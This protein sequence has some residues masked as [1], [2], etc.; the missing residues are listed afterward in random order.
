[1]KR[2][3]LIGL[4]LSAILLCFSACTNED[5]GETIQSEIRIDESLL[6]NGLSFTSEEGSQSISFSTNEDWSLNVATT[7]SGVVWCTASATSGQKGDAT[8]E[9]TVT[10]NNS[11]D[12]RNVAVTIQ[13]GTASKTFSIS[14]KWAD[15]LL[16]TTDK[17]EISQTGGTIEIEVNANIDYEMEIAEDSKKW[18]TESNTRALTAYKHTLDIAINEELE[19]REG[20]IYFKSGDKIETVKVYQAGGAIIMLSQNEYKISDAGE[21]ITIN[22]KSNIEY[23]VLMP[24]VDWITDEASTRGLSSHTLKYIISPND[25]YDSRSAEIIFYD[26]NSELKEAV[27][28]VQTQKNAIILS[29]KQITIDSDSHTIEV[30]VSANVDFNIEMPDVDWISHTLPT[31]GLTDHIVKF[32]VLENKEQKNREAQIVFKDKESSLS[33]TLII[34]QHSDYGDYIIYTYIESIDHLEQK[35]IQVT[36]HRSGTLEKTINLIDYSTLKGAYLLKVV[37][38]INGDDIYYIREVFSG[39]DRLK[40]YELDLSEA[41]IVEGGKEYYY[42]YR[43]SRNTIEQSMF[44]DLS[45]LRS[46][47][48]PDSAISIERYALEF[49]TELVLATIGNGVTSIGES[50]FYGCSKLRQIVIPDS[51]TTLESSV[52]SR[53]IQLETAIIG[54]EATSI[55]DY[56]FDDCENLTSVTIGNSVTSIGYQAFDGCENLTSVIIPNSVTKIGGFAFH[57]CTSLEYATLGNGIKSIAGG[58]FKNCSALETIDVPNSVE[59]IENGA[60]QNCSS[61]K[62]I[63]IGEGVATIEADVFKGC[64]A[65][66][67]VYITNLSAWC[68]ISFPG[69]TT[70]HDYVAYNN[71]LFNNAKL[72]LNNKE[73]K[74]LV[75]PEEIT[76]INSN[77]FYGCSSITSVSVGDNVT[78]IGWY[79]FRNCASITSVTLGD[80]V[81]LIGRGAFNHCRLLSTLS[82]G[83]NVA[84]IDEI[85]FYGSSNITEC[86]CFNPTPPD[87]CYEYPDYGTYSTFSIRKTDANVLYVPKG[88]WEIYYWY[89]QTKWYK[90]FNIEEME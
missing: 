26:K 80:N 5:D 47:I 78:E 65:L 68:N 48:L 75:I 66:S 82:L 70:G 54:S 76:R 62:S 67:S 85:A 27:K 79:A 90:H 64:N 35:A 56:A 86:F 73:L 15:A 12:N 23:G 61:L 28:I 34:N 77:A 14:Q 59:F 41:S 17:Y 44:Y 43:T 29:E 83:K 32:S 25:G 42:N 16:V 7:T 84:K 72:Y 49:C 45:R 55:G 10:E 21:V 87:I 46:I 37:G 36:L 13:S 40:C 50:A 53:C 30:K 58:A 18:I 89:G 4:A 81:T 1:M 71:P 33:E 6:L 38:A 51:V 57:D 9:F 2:L 88:C 39:K 31:R 69:A 22:V 52:F 74:E 8:V 11:Y 3:K 60:F 20:E 63:T 19:K 24:D